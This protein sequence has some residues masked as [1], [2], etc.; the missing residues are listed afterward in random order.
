VK[1]GGRTRRR[2][3]AQGPR[4]PR[5]AFATVGLFA[6]LSLAACGGGKSAVNPGAQA[7]SADQVMFGV[8]QYLTNLGVKQAYLRADSA[9]IYEA[10]GRVDLKKVGVTFYSAEG[11]EMSTLTSQTGVYWMRTN[12]MSA[13][14]NVVVVRTADGA[15]LHTDFLKYDP[16]KNQVTT[17][18][19]Y[20][21]DKGTQHIEGDQG[22]TCDPGFTSCTTVGARGTAGR[23]VMPGQ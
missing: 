17:D 21:A 15:T 16:T 14:G 8:K 5:G 11:A 19:P 2:A 23:L 9:F 22:F 20:V 4:A 3:D 1:T 10:S 7:D 13:Q 12:Q 6:S 18:K